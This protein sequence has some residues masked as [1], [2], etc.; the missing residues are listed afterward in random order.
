[1]YSMIFERE[2]CIVVVEWRDW[3]S[4][5][6][7]LILDGLTFVGMGRIIFRVRFLMSSHFW[8]SRGNAPDGNSFT[9]V[10]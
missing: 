9:G 6:S 3:V 10:K 4:I 2:S 7:R 1:M 5:A 8:S